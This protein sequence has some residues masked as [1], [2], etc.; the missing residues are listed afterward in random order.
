M[1]ELENDTLI[2]TR[3]AETGNGPLVVLSRKSVSFTSKSISI[4]LLKEPTD[5]LEFSLDQ[6]EYGQIKVQDM[7]VR[8]NRHWSLQQ[9]F[10]H[11]RAKIMKLFV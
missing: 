9:R 8:I 4:R 2:L 6:A 5:M 11:F 7:C 1:A 3:S 10:S